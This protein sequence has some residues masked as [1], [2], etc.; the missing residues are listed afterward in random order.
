[1]CLFEKPSPLRWIA[2]GSFAWCMGGARRH[3]GA[4]LRRPIGSW[5]DATSPKL[6]QSLENARRLLRDRG[7]R[8]NADGTLLDSAGKPVEF[9]IIVSAS[10]PERVQMATVIQ[11]DL[12]KLG[13]QV[14][15]VSL[16]FRALLDRVLNSRQYE[17]CILGLVSGDADPNPEMNV[18]LSS[19]G[20]HLWNPNQEKPITAW[21]AE[22]DGLMRR[23]MTTLDH[24]E[25]KRLYDRV[26]Q[27]AAENLPLICLA[28]PNILVA[29]RKDLGNFQP[30]IVDHYTL[31]N[32]EQLYWRRAAGDARAKG[33]VE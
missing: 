25:R 27:I 1:M 6:P 4:M 32:V 18:W 16:E 22:I 24:A 10:S 21:E 26:Q 3:Y 28:S 7:F 15:V 14:Q 33:G 12:K 19:G 2:T 5:L 30:A 20:S 11:D 23:Q 8:W 9:S 29:A 13:I 31:W 17:A